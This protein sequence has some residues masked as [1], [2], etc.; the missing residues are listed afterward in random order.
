MQVSGAVGSAQAR[1]YYKVGPLSQ[2]FAHS[3]FEPAQL[4]DSYYLR[5][6]YCQDKTFDGKHD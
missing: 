3:I 6:K 1:V 4:L 2:D 5:P